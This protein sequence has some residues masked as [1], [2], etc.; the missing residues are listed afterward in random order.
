MALS[1]VSIL[2]VVSLACAWPHAARSASEKKAVIVQMFEWNWDSVAAECTSFLGPAGYGFVQ[3]SPAQEHVQGPEWWTDYQP[4]SY[5]LTSKRG[6][7]EQYENMIHTCHAAGVGVIADTIWNHMTAQDSGKGVAGSDFTH[8]DYPGIY[9]DQDFHHCGLE[10]NDTIVDFDNKV[11]VWTCE[12][13]GLADLATETDYVRGR[14]AEYTND[15]ISLG[16]DGLRLDAAKHMDPDDIAD[17]LSRLTSQPYVTQEVIWGEG[18]PVTPDLYIGNGEV[19]EFRYTS[20]LRDA[21]LG[22]DGGISSLEDLDG[23]G[24]V[25]G[26]S[27][28]AFVSNHDTERNK[29]SLNVYSPSNAYTLASVFS[30]AH[31]YGRVSVL[32]SYGN[33]FNTDAGAPSLGMVTIFSDNR[34]HTT[35]GFSSPGAGS[36]NGSL[37]ADWWL[38]QHRWIPLA[39]MVRFRNQVG[40][41]PVTGWVSPSSQQIA[42]SRGSDGFVAIN[43]ADSAWNTTFMTGL[44]GG[45]Y[46]NVID[47]SS[48]PEGTCTGTAF[49]I[50]PDG[51]MTVTV[52]AHQAIAMHTGALGYGTSGP[53]MMEL[54]L[55]P[56]LFNV[57]ATTTFGENIFVVGD[58]PGLGNLDPTNAI[59]LDPSNHP[60]WAATAY[61]PPNTAFQYSF[62]RKEPNGTVISESAPA[63]EDMTP[64]SGI[65]SIVTSWR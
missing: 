28:N 36:C 5:I 52:G 41:A 34:N 18:Q 63:R 25:A 55:V 21:F 35:F 40:R 23:R 27:A 48:S 46:C 31:P 30:L 9:K 56:V 65:L 47:G 8:Y 44:P 53:K 61:L 38:C 26:S 39:G 50:G 57:N 15:L 17:I 62:I 42:F 6:M 14:L 2:S 49:T 1:L 11:E 58:V 54:G 32:S 60:L 33:F 51:S 12:L 24:W 19:Q 64:A 20:A 29:G 13:G 37:S 43:N 7:R 4:V 59:P 45:S 22:L 10:P 3:V 16:A